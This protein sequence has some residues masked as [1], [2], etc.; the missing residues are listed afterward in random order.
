MQ[1]CSRA[2]FTHSVAWA[3]DISFI[4]VIQQWCPQLYAQNVL[5][6]VPLLTTANSCPTAR[7]GLVLRSLCHDGGAAG[8]NRSEHIGQ[9]EASAAPPCGCCIVRQVRHQ[10]FPQGTCPA[11]SCPPLRDGGVMLHLGK[12]GWEAGA[13]PSKDLGCGKLGPAATEGWLHG[14]WWCVPWGKIPGGHL[15]N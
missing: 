10:G 7:S 5:L 14:F 4:H 9:G 3:A 8:P 6:A 2:W 12:P 11:S 15:C 13:E 1:G